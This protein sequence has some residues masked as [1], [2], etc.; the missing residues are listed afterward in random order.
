M[1][2]EALVSL[3]SSL[4]TKVIGREK[5]ERS[6]RETKPMTHKGKKF[7]IQD[8]ELFSSAKK[9]VNESKVKGDCEFEHNPEKD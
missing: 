8:Q 2:N 1:G 9:A 5:N 7:S 3:D 4:R 6:D